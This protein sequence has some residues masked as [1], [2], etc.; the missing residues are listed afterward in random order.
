MLVV[1]IIIFAIAAIFGLLN[2]IAILSSKQ[3]SKPVVYIHGLLAAIALIFLIIFTVN[4]A[5]SSPIL[6]L[7]LFII[8]AIVGFILFARDLS[9]KPGP[10]AVALIHG[11]IA[12]ISFIIL[13]IFAINM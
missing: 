7:V 9:K 2:L 3:T 4:S 8:V 10:K 13:I 1:S 11:I 6:S 5:G 12:V